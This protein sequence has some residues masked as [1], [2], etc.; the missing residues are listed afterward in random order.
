MAEAL[1]APARAPG[2][3]DPEPL[4]VETDNS[5]GVAAG[6]LGAIGNLA[7][8]RID[9]VP[10]LVDLGAGIENTGLME[11]AVHMIEV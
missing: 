7:C 10:A 3:L 4:F 5:K 11:G 2:V 1:S 6:L 9:L 8:A